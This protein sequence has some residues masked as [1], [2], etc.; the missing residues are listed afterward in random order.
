MTNHRILFMNAS[1]WAAYR[2]LTSI[3]LVAY[4]LALGASNTTIGLLGALPW[5]ATIL[6]QI[7]GAELVQRYSRKH[8]CVIFDILSRLCW[9]PILL[10]PFLSDH[11]LT[12]IVIFYLFSELAATITSPGFNSLLA[13]TVST[14]HR[15]DFVSIRFRLINLFGMLAMVLGGL[16]LKQFPR[17][18]PTGFA[19]MFALGVLIGLLGA[20]V[21]KRIKEPRYRDHEHHAIKEFFTLKGSMKR[22]VLFSSLFSFSLMLASPFIAVYML[23]NLNMGYGFYGIA[24]AAS[25]LSK[26]IFSHYIGKLTDKYGDKPFSLIG[27]LS[28]AAIP[29]LFL[30]ITES[31]VWLVIPLQIYSGL[32]WAMV[33]IAHYNLLLDLSVPKKRALQIAEYNIYAN[34]PR[35]VAPVIGGWI[36]DN[37]AFILAGIPLI[38][39]LS[40]ILRFTTS[41]IILT[42]KE[43][44][45]KKE[46]PLTYVIKHA[47][48]FHPNKGLEHSM[49]VIKRVATGLFK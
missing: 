23:K 27:H 20:V 24:I 14:K 45:V 43:P 37:L 2:G 15:G 22:Y 3:Y 49:H 6:T 32:A 11:P 26:I 5:L 29:A 34:A 35:V 48:Q 7:P 13:D 41:L 8:L 10:A 33:D 9:I 36:V 46:Y 4:A 1:F 40:S 21:L 44:R 16:W 30:A 47:V 28:T 19:I 39:V 18:S 17:E 42:I 25:T 31:T 12:I 38:F